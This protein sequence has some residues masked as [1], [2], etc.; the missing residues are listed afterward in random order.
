MNKK[1]KIKLSI[2]YISPLICAFVMIQIG[3]IDI[4]FK[5]AIIGIYDFIFYSKELSGDSAIIFD[6]RLPRIFLAILVGASLAGCGAIMQSIFKNPLIDP[7][8][9]GISSGAALGCAMSIGIFPQI[10]LSVLAF[11]GAIGSSIFILLIG[12]VSNNIS[13]IL[14]GVVIAAF[15]GALTSLI[16]FFVPAEKSQ[17]I[18]I[19]LLGSLSLSSWNDVLLVGAGFLVTFTPLFLL[20]NKINILSLQDSEA[21]SLGIN[22]WVLKSMCMLLISF[23]C[24][25]CVSVSGTIGWIGLIV[26]HIA[27]FLIGANMKTL[28][29]ASIA[30][31]ASILLV[32]DGIAR[33]I[34][35]FD[36]PL[37]AINAIIFAPFFIILLYRQ[38]KKY[39]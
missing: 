24:A 31:G 1:E 4:N 21:I 30:I 33:G 5:N 22:I 20:R 15:L 34:S 7:F 27:R 36:L 14:S 28:L 26:P 2:I 11:L 10:N 18:T 17:A 8:L 6:T 29:P 32:G 38:I 19:W 12:R 9:L 16:Q 23:I 13:L 35:T 37:G 39:A 3:A 25:L